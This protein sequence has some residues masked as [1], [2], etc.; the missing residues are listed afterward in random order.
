MYG[1]KI[2]FICISLAV[3][4]VENTLHGAMYSTMHFLF[5]KEIGYS[6]LG[7]L[8]PAVGSLWGTLHSTVYCS[9]WNRNWSCETWSTF[10]PQSSRLELLYVEPLTSMAKV[11]HKHLSCPSQAVIWK[12]TMHPW[13]NAVFSIIVWNICCLRAC[14]SLS[15][16]HFSATKLIQI[17]EEGCTRCI[18][19]ITGIYQLF[20]FSIKVLCSIKK[21]NLRNVLLFFNIKKI[22]LKYTVQYRN[23][24]KPFKLNN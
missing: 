12:N 7:Q 2:H 22:S 15:L 1:V 11:H 16:V 4:S 10:S 14:I 18:F 19:S 5:V 13:S 21:K 20:S 17:C 6:L 23:Q 8:D 3:V 9:S 24:Q